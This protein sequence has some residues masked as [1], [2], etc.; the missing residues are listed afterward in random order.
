M[1]SKSSLIGRI[2]M[3]HCHRNVSH[4]HTITHTDTHTYTHT[5]T[6]THKCAGEGASIDFSNKRDINVD[7]GCF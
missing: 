5:Y 4:T 6:P 2:M 3:D 7:K 1:C